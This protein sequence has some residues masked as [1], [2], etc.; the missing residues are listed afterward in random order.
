MS[1]VALE[2]RVGRGIEFRAYAEVGCFAV[3]LHS[4]VLTWGREGL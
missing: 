4:P 2:F 1:F 3:R